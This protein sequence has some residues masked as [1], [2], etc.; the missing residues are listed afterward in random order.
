MEKLSR[1]GLARYWLCMT[2]MR[3]CEG[4]HGVHQKRV[5]ALVSFDKRWGDVEVR[6]S[7]KP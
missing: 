7:S 6:E 4:Q 3:I 1:T 2:I 5:L